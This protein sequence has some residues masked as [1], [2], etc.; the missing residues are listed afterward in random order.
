MRKLLLFDNN[1]RFQLME[2]SLSSSPALPIVHIFLRILI[3]VNWMGG[4]AILALL[5]VSPNREWIMSAFD[6]IPSPETDRLVNGLRAIALVGLVTIPINFGVLRRLLWIVES[7]RDGDPFVAV[8]ATR[9][10]HIAWA[11]LTL[12]FLSMLIAGIG[13]MVSSPAHPLALDAGF[14]I[15]AWLAVLFTFVLARVFAEGTRLRDDLEGTV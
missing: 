12:Q 2:K 15:N 6:L 3:V 7:V 13:K 10:R 5:L 14:S 11:M 1:G 9:L 8:N 4:L